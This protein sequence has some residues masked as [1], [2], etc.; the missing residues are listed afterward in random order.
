MA[1]SEITILTT[2]VNA[3]EQLGTLLA[4][5]NIAQSQEQLLEKVENVQRQMQGFDNLLPIHQ[6]TYLIR[7]LI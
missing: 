6:I 7:L 3:A 5:I 4:S 2:L 1:K